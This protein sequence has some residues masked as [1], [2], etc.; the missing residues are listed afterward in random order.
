M[1]EKLPGHNCNIPGGGV[2][3]IRPGFIVQTGAVAKMGAGHTQLCGAGIHQLHK[4][5]FAAGDRLRQRCGAVIG[6]GDHHAFDHVP[7]RHFLAFLQIYLTAAFGGGCCG[8]GNG[9]LPMELPPVDGLH[10]E[11]QCHHLGD[12][13]WCQLLIRVFLIKNR[14]GGR[15]HQ[16]TAWSSHLRCRKAGSCAYGQCQK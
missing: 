2:M 11:Q 6:R 7:Q 15:I 4:A 13:G 3:L 9:V 1:F 5:A 8:G 12:T 10:H 16:N 14:S